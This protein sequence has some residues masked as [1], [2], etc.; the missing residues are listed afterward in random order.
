MIEDTGAHVHWHALE[1]VQ[2]D[3]GSFHLEGG[4]TSGDGFFSLNWDWLR[5]SLSSFIQMADIHRHQRKIV[6]EQILISIL[7]SI[8]IFKFFFLLQ[9]L[10]F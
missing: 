7:V 2:V 10:L 6:W 1:E 5:L 3:I 9:L 4:D 8:L